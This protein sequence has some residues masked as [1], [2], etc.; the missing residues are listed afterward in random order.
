MFIPATFL[1][2]SIFGTQNTSGSFDG[3]R[4]KHKN[5]NILFD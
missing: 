1:K 3:F 2:T 4:K 5:K